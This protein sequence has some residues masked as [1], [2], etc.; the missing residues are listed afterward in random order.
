MRRPNEIGVQASSIA[1]RLLFT[2]RIGGIG[3]LLA[4]GSAPVPHLKPGPQVD[5]DAPRLAVWAGLASHRPSAASLA[6]AS[7]VL[8]QRDPQHPIRIGRRLERPLHASPAYPWKS[9]P[10][11]NKGH[12]GPPDDHR[13]RGLNA[14]IVGCSG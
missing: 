2:A 5:G 4:C 6:S 11:V 13:N 7:I 8:P 3:R 12:R 1:R 9:P 14:L 10:E